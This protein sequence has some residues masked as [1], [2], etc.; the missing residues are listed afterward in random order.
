MSESI[1]FTLRLAVTHRTHARGTLAQSLALAIS[2][3]AGKRE[4][5]VI[6]LVEGVTVVDHEL[7]TEIQIP[8]G[9]SHD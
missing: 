1:E 9:L 5:P 3:A 4:L 2:R 7:G 8:G 6:G